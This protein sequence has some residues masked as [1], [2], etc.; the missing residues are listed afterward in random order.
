MVQNL[1]FSTVCC[2]RQD[3]CLQIEL[4][5]HS[6]VLP[7]RVPAS[8]ILPAFSNVSAL[9]HHPTPLL[10]C[11]HCTPIAPCSF[12]LTSSRG[13]EIYIRYLSISNTSQHPD[14]ERNSAPVQISPFRLMFD[15]ASWKGAHLRPPL[16]W[17]LHV[18]LV[19]LANHVLL[20]R[21]WKWYTMVN[22]TTISGQNTYTRTAS[23]IQRL[24]VTSCFSN[25]EISRQGWSPSANMFYVR[26]LLRVRMY[27]ASVHKIK[28]LTV[29]SCTYQTE[30]WAYLCILSL[31]QVNRIVEWLKLEGTLKIIKF[32]PECALFMQMKDHICKQ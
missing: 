27:N 31:F 25:V 4:Q 17:V 12:A 5:N 15:D 21:Q 8:S 2:G 22:A 1:Y 26:I 13:I 11:E 10:R 24:H 30:D 6:Q 28:D 9:P 29:W 32:S 20:W 7:H 18:S 16:N 19:P 14:A 3:S 23:I